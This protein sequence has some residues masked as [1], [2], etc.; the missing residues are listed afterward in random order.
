VAYFGGT[1][2]TTHHRWNKER[3]R[4]LVRKRNQKSKQRVYF[5]S[6]FFNY[7]LNRVGKLVPKR[8][9]KINSL[10]FVSSEISVV[11]TNFAILA[12]SSHRLRAKEWRVWV[13][14]KLY[15]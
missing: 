3:G 8:A 7:P 11:T 13:P 15:L 14:T 5:I 2:S 12:K 4:H 10:G 9:K 6:K 1:Y